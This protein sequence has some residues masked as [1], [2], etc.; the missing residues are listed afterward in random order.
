MSRVNRGIARGMARKQGRPSQEGH[1][2]SGFE[3]FVEGLTKAQRGI[4]EGLLFT[5]FATTVYR[6]L[7]YELH[8]TEKFHGLAVWFSTNV[9]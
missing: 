3:K 5:L 6:L 1:T 7:D 9:N 4:F 8:L 2:P